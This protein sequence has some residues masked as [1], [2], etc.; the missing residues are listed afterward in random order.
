MDGEG[1]SFIFYF[2][3]KTWFT[4]SRAVAFHKKRVESVEKKVGEEEE[5]KSHQ[6]KSLIT[7]KQF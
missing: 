2:N 6:C 7:I 1:E 4:W 3:V 5:K